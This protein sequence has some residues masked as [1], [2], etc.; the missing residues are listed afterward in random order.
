MA[1]P[2]T[3]SIVVAGAD[4]N[5]MTLLRQTVQEYWELVAYQKAISDGIFAMAEE[6]VKQKSAAPGN[7]S[8]R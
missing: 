7:Q 2:Y 8:G 1:A 4:G 3:I 6:A 5:E